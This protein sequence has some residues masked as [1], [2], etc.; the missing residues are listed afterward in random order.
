MGEF[1]VIDYKILITAM[2]SL[3]ALVGYRE[4]FAISEPHRASEMYITQKKNQLLASD[5]YSYLVN[6]QEVCTT[7]YWATSKILGNYG[8]FRWATDT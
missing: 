3:V 1:L 6:F 5:N 2:W 4:L 8:V 7:V